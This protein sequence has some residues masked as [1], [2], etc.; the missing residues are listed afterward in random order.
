MTTKE[1]LLATIQERRNELGF[2]QTEI[3]EKLGISQGQYARLESGKSEITVEKLIS[4]C[5]LLKMEV[6]IKRKEHQENNK[7]DEIINDI[8]KVLDK[9]KNL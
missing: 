5:E 1:L 8:M 9:F 6:N 3:A 4:L 7:K 2:S